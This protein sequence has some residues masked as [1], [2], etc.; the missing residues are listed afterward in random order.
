[1]SWY[2]RARLVLTPGN[3]ALFLRSHRL[4]CKDRKYSVVN[5]IK[6]LWEVSKNERIVRH[7]KMF[8]HSSFLPPIPSKAADQ[9][10]DAV[11]GEGTVFEDHVNARRRAPIS[12]YVAVTG[13]CEYRCL[14]CSAAEH[15]QYDEWDFQELIKLFADLQDMGTAIIGLTGGEP[16][17]RED[18]CDLISSIDDRSVTFLFTSGHGLTLERA[19]ELNRAGLFGVG[20]SLDSAVPAAMDDM[21]GVEGA[22][23]NAVNGIK[24]CRIAGLYTMTQVAINR[25]KLSS[26]TLED[27][28]RLSASLGV[29]EVRILETMPTGRLRRVESSEILNVEE[30]DELKRFHERMNHTRDYPKVSVFAHTEDYSRYG[31]GAGTQHSYIDST[32]NLYPCDFV[33]LSFANIRKE[34]VAEAWRKMH[35]AI[36]KPRRQCMIMELYS[37]KLLHDKTTFPLSTD[38]S[39]KCLNQMEPI[40]KM[41]GF[42]RRLKGDLKNEPKVGS[43]ACLHPKKEADEDYKWG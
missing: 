10:L 15:S 17:L 21:R 20:I 30:R 9:V 28:V 4:F 38:E 13:K 26:D 40:N 24:N 7:N 34:P 6:A 2:N 35:S 22:F 12:M 39:H 18:L 36:G 37:Q 32:G 16:L 29:H 33:P 3:I 8:V 23:D 42:Y 14:H 11:A 25:K 43:P 27:I 19:K 31:C 41:P 5:L 1:M